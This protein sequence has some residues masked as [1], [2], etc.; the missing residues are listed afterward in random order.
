MSI[1]TERDPSLDV[2]RAER[3]SI[4]TTE[5]SDRFYIKLG[6]LLEEA[7]RA[8]AKEW[9]GRPFG[10]L[11]AETTE[12]LFDT[13]ARIQGMHPCSHGIAPAQFCRWCAR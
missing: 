7:V 3:D 8:R 5:E 1:L 13:G 12:M 9:P 6:L 11:G 10:K 4:H 2:L